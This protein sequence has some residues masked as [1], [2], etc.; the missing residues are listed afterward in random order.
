VRAVLLVLGK[1]VRT[2]ARTPALLA[3]LV[4]YPLLIAALLG[5]VAGY[6]SSKPRVAF[7]DE[8]GLPAN[9]VVGTHRFDV[10]ATIDEVAKNVKLVRVGQDEARRELADGR[11]VAV[12]T[13]PPGFVATLQQMVHSP[14][15][16]LAV[17]RGGTSS[18]VR[19]QV[20]AL[21]YSLNTKLQRA[22]IDANL[23]Y[24]KLILHG[25]DGSFL[26]EQFDVLGLDGTV[27][28]LQSLPQNER[29]QK[30]EHFVHDARLALAQTNEALRATAA[31][32]RLVE[33][34][35]RGRS[36]SLSAQV[37]SYALGLTITFLA[38]VLAA[39]ALAGERDEN[40]L[41]R[42]ARGLVG[43]GR[44][45]A[46]KVALAALVAAALGLGVALVF[47]VAIVVGNAPGGEPWQRLPLLAAGLA[48]T[49]AALG[50]VGT[51]V[52]ALAREARTASLAAVLLVLPVVFLGLIPAEVFAAAGWASDALPFAHG[53][54]L[55]SAT[56]YDLHPWGAVAREA[57]WLAGLTLVFSLLARAAVRPFEP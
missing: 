49:G 36:A 2:L 41:G 7:V 20:Q 18:R 40:V 14:T 16:E 53:V 32:I 45:V 24:V 48:L 17:T 29:V 15:L 3:V 13:V 38:L 9:I 51:L 23:Q 21:V 47:A 34:P 5:L 39:G 6:A 30:I 8:D 25:G 33:V 57:A 56:L 46:A 22:Y 11:V 4:V 42:L 12:V 28:L 52:G 19:Q 43:P 55:F 35:Q 1:D 26:G 54:R 50:A 27:K 10:N 44:L 37:E 31:P